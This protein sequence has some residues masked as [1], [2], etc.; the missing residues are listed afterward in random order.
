M[1]V[2]K[3]TIL[4]IQRL[5]TEDG[6]GLRT[7]VFFKGCSLACAWCHNPESIKFLP[8]IQWIE[9]S[10]CIG[11]GLCVQACPRQGL[12]SGANGIEIDRE[13]CEACGSC[14]DVCP[15][16]AMEIK[17][18]VWELDDLLEEV[19]KDISFFRDDGGV[20]FSGGEA[21]MQADFVIAALKRLREKGIHT[22]V[23][24]A[25]LVSEKAMLGAIEN[26]DMIL[27][28]LKI[29]DRE[30]H[31]KNTGASNDVILKNARLLADYKRK[32]GTPSIWI[33]TPV[34]PN[35]TDSS[36]N[37]SSIGKFISEY[38]SDT[39]DRWEL[40]AFN[41]LCF[42]KYKRLGGKWEFE[43]VE[44]VED[45]T[46]NRLTAVAQKCDID[47]DKILWTGTTRMKNEEESSSQ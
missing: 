31:I 3:A 36:D 17:G 37:I 26:A 18:E 42:T 12:V 15:T 11:C 8:Q 27:F 34:I 13:M 25:G 23:D 21:L 14:V 7:T 44:K 30:K 1:S 29:L 6:P 32:H 20:T 10:R 41:N 24:T 22:A 46:M 5:S 45:E 28:D 38:M 47:S 43:N 33:R 16:G 39:I 9:N 19:L 4:D 2:M 40:C 35:A